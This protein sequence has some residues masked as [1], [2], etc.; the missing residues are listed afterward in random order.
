MENF[1]VLFFMVLRLWLVLGAR[2]CARQAE[3]RRLR[4][5]RRMKSAKR[6]RDMQEAI[7]KQ[8]NTLLRLRQRRRRILCVKDFCAAA[9]A[10]LLPELIHLPDEGKFREIAS[11]FESRW[12]LPQCVGAIDGSHIPI[13]APRTFHTDYFNRKGWHSLILQAV[14]DGKGLF[15]NVF[16]GLPGSMHDARVLRLSSIWHLASRGNL[17]P[18]HSIQIAGVDFG[19][20][21][22]GDSAYP[23]QDWLLKPFTDTGRLTEQQLLF[24]KKFSR[25]RVVVENAFGRLKGRWRCLLKRNDCDVSLVRSMILTCCALH[26]LCESHGEHYDNVWTTETEYPEPVAAPPPPQNTGDVGGK[27]KRDA[28]MMHLVGQ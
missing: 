14:V 22:L 24:N 19:Y 2:L 1:V 27:A 26:N 10:W 17:F 6:R 13:I 15:W 7:L 28:L 12:G 9:E 20:C 18:D 11:Y 21:I 16:A 8:Y 25:A 4:Q 5:L 3:R 23:L